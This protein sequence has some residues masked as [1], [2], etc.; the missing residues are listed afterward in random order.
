MTVLAEKLLELLPTIALWE[1]FEHALLMRPCIAQQ[2]DNCTIEI[3][4]NEMR[5]DN[6]PLNHSCEKQRAKFEFNASRHIG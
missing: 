5:E 1:R 3:N 6:S 2:K 4:A